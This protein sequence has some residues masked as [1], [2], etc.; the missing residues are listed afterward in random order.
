MASATTSNEPQR[1]GQSRDGSDRTWNVVV[2]FTTL[3]VVLA[4]YA[5]LETARD[6]LFLS[7]LSARKLPWAYLATAGAVS[8]LA[9]LVPS[10][11]RQASRR[12]TGIL[13]WATGAAMLVAWVLDPHRALGLYALY[14]A[15]GVAGTLVLVQLW[16]LI[17]AQL[18]IR[19]ARRLFAIIA[20]GGVLGTMAG[21][22]LAARVVDDHGARALLGLGAVGLAVAGFGPFLLRRRSTT[23]ADAAEPEPTAPLVHVY[24]TQYARRIFWM[25]ALTTIAT[26][27][28]DFIFKGAVA[29]SR[30]AADLGSFFAMYQL[31]INGVGLLMQLLVAPLLFRRVGAHRMVL[32]L[33]LLTLASALGFVFAPGLIASITMKSIDGSLRSSVHRTSTEV[34]YLPLP[35]GVRAKLKTLVDGVGQ[36]SAQALASLL[37]LAAFAF[38]AHSTE[39]A[40]VVGLSAGACLWVAWGLR[41]HYVQAFR[42][43]LRAG[44]LEEHAAAAPLDLHSLQSLV[45]MLDSP[46]DARVM[47]ALD[48]L[49]AQ[50]KVS[51]IPARLLR[52]PS[53]PVVQ[54]VLELVAGTGRRNLAL[55]VAP[56]LAHADPKVSAVAA[57]VYAARLSDERALRRLADDARVPVRAAG[58]VALA[59]IGK[60]T[61]RDRAALQ[62]LAKRGPREGRLALLRAAA[63]QPR[64]ELLPLIVRLSEA[65]DPE[66]RVAAA[67]ALEACG[68]ARALPLALELLG[69]RQVRDDARDIFRDSGNRGIAFL[70]AALGNDALDHDVRRHIP[71]TLSRFGNERAAAILLEGLSR[72]IGDGVT[73]YKM[74]RGL[75]R[76]RRD[77]PSLRLDA[78]ALKQLARAAVDRTRT[79]QRWRDSFGDDPANRS[80][81]ASGAGTL[82]KALLARKARLAGERLFRMLDLMRPGEELHPIYEGLRHGDRALRASSRELLEYQLDPAL[83]RSVLALVDGEPDPYYRGPRPPLEQ[84]LAAMRADHSPAVRALANEYTGQRD[85]ARVRHVS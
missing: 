79:L 38:G 54:R 2:S 40:L 18:T 80:A 4:A 66:L 50:G 74:L 84:T 32:L 8:L 46:D 26:T 6:T 44:R 20:A 13:L 64:P 9:W 43:Q 37:V 23:V 63:E 14:T 34:L 29:G 68:D 75:G 73:R 5:L 56:L 78:N 53:L 42:D 45:A 49:V 62:A 30:P 55:Q 47:A 83:R 85:R 82:L 81:G 72:H 24:R 39:L 1:A 27:V 11:T 70:T 35:L 3:F 36:R 67:R 58:L 12:R 33:P 28:G 41:R 48:A 76:M 25:V 16:T 22:F 65:D 7:H 60:Q 71:R 52:H 59:R 57:R 10:L 69:R 77:R 15:V 21:S 19:E 51:L 61:A 17:G 31:V